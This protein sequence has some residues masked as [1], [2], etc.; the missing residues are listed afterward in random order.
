MADCCKAGKPVDGK[1]KTIRFEKSRQKDK[2]EH[3][4]KLRLFCMAGRKPE[5]PSGWKVQLVG[6]QRHRKTRAGRS[7]IFSGL[8][9]CAGCGEKLYYGAANNCRPEGVFFGCSLHWKRKDKCGT[10]YI[11]EAVLSHIVLKHI[12]TVT[13]CILRHEVHFRTVMRTV[14]EEQLR[15]E[16]GE[17]IRIRRKRLERNEN[18]IAELKRQFIYDGLGFIPL[19]ELMKEETA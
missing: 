19:N 10:P 6:Q 1:L 11:R 12:Q 18:P 13:G 8:V 4:E 15:L 5:N 16:S 9:Y 7:G 17:Q 3:D 2:A 14:M